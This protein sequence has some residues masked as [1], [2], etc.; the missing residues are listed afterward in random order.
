MKANMGTL[1]RALRL[2]VAAVIAVLYFTDRI[3]GTLAIILGVFA[4]VFL[5][6]SVVARCPAYLPIGLD[7]RGKTDGG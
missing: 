2:L 6:T 4:T 5:V 3:G 1:D 7:T